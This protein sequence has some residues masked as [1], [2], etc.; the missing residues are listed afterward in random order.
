MC[1]NHNLKDLHGVNT[2]ITNS[3]T[4][5]PGAPCTPFQVL[6]PIKT[7]NIFFYEV[8]TQLYFPHFYW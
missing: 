8:L 3:L 4:R 2:R 7:T 1:P 6:S 5:T